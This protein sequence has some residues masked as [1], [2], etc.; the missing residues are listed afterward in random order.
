MKCIVGEVIDKLSPRPEVI[1]EQSRQENG[2]SIAELRGVRE[3]TAEDSHLCWGLRG[4][5]FCLGEA[6]MQVRQDGNKLD[7]NH[8]I[9]KC[10]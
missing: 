2:V 10:S 8:N 4:W 5:T 1:Y 7:N 9:V 3:V 6:S